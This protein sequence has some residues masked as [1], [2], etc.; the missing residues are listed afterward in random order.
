VMPLEEY[1]FILVRPFL[2][3]IIYSLVREKTLVRM[4]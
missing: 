4:Q 1:I 2:A 3:L